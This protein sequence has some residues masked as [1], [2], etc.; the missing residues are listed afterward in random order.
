M[1]HEV[2][3]GGQLVTVSAV[4]LAITW[5][6]V[7]LRVFVRLQI[8]KSFQAEDWLMS[9]SQVS[10]FDHPWPLLQET[11]RYSYKPQIVFTLTC[12]FIFVGVHYGIGRHDVTLPNER[13][14]ESRKVDLVTSWKRKCWYHSGDTYCYCNKY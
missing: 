9:V 14:I 3:N 8:T 13:K 5:I 4:F 10:C 7:L 11:S 1:G 6:S 12:V 2:Y